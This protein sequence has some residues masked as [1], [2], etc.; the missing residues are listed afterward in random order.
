MPLTLKDAVRATV[1]EMR[2]AKADAGMDAVSI[3]Q[4]LTSST[5]CGVNGGSV[6]DEGTRAHDSVQHLCPYN[7]CGNSKHGF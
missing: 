2:A 1:D 5:L 6:A 7:T 4:A 3:V